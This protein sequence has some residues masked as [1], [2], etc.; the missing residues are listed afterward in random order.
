MRMTS[1]TMAAFLLISAMALPALSETALRCTHRES[2]A[3]P[4]LLR[5]LKIGGRVKLRL[6]VAPD[7]KVTGT[8][9]EGGN[10][11][12]AELSCIAAKKWTYAAMPKASD[13]AVELVFDPALAQP[14]VTE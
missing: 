2:P 10:P 3:Y 4:V 5:S 11:V 9:V 7:G 6:T 14:T 12:L 1:K 13:V 8:K